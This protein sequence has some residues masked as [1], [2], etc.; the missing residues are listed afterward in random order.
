MFTRCEVKMK[1]RVLKKGRLA[2]TF[3][4]EPG[5]L[6][7][8]ALRPPGFTPPRHPFLN[9]Q[10]HDAMSEQELADLLQRS[11]SAADFV[12]RLEKHGYEVRKEE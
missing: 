1:F 9:G 7:S 11:S 3:T 10:A 12:T 2:L 5:V 6:L 4:D 8:T